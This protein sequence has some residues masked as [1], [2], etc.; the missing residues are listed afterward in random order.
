MK[1]RG[2]Y[3][4]SFKMR[5]PSEVLNVFTRG[6]MQLKKCWRD[7]HC[8][9]AHKEVINDMTLDRKVEFLCIRLFR[10]GIAQPVKLFERICNSDNIDY[11][12][13]DKHEFKKLVRYIMR[14][15]DGNDTAKINDISEINPEHEKYCLYS[16]PNVSENVTF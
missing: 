12:K 5:A 6:N 14:M 2:I 7:G 16:G 13:F 3:Y 4:D 10:N 11:D 9:T 8:T 1:K 15:P